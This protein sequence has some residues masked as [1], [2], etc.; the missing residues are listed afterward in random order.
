M[1]HTERQFQTL[2]SGSLTGPSGA[3]PGPFRNHLET[4]SGPQRGL[5]WALRRPQVPTREEHLKLP[6]QMLDSGSLS[7]P[8]GGPLPRPC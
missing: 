1:E 8:N 6:F 7:T 2:H 5:H 4:P 3:P